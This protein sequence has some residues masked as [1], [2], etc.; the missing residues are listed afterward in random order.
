MVTSKKRGKDQTMTP[1]APQKPKDPP[2]PMIGSSSTWRQDELDR[3][4][5]QVGNEVAVTELI[6]Q[7]WFDF[8][9]IE[10]YE[11]GKVFVFGNSL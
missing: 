9:S 2:K 6:P 5:V 3:F 8:S 1:R 4:E 11:S 10:E 7:K